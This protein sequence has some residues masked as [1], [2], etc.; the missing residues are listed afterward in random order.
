MA[1]Y[2]CFLES[3]PCIRQEQHQHREDLQTA[4]QHIK[5]H[6]QLCGVRKAAKVHHGAYLRKARADVVQSSCNGCEVRHHIKAIQTDEQE[7]DHEDE[8]IRAHKHIGGADGLVVQQ[9]AVHA[10]GGHHLWV[11]RLLE[12]LAKGLAQNEDAA[13]LDAAAG[14]ARAGT[15]EHEHHQNFFGEGG[16]QVKITAGKTGSGDDGTHLKGCLTHRFAKAVI[17]AVDIGRDNANCHQNNGEVA[18]HLLADDAVEFT[19]QQQEVGIEVD[20]EQDHEDSHDPLDVGRKAGKAVV[21]EAE[22]AGARRAEG[23][24]H[25]LKQRHAA[26]HQEYQLQHG[27]CKIDAVQDL[28]GRL[29]LGHQLIHLRTGAFCLHQVDVGAAG[30]GQASEVGCT[31]FLIEK[32]KTLGGLARQISQ[33]PEKTRIAHFPKYLEKRAEKLHDLF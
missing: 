32:E 7:G 14:A 8:E 1:F 5:D 33:I 26:Q 10:D 3:A 29:H 30:Q 13:H 18:A 11:Q 31:T 4:G 25:G 23:R 22:A 28:C 20:T 16:P 24:E 2:N 15:N 21:L 12:L 17:K 9:L 27:E 19:Q 6:H